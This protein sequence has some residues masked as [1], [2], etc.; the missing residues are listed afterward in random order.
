MKEFSW[1]NDREWNIGELVLETLLFSS[2]VSITDLRLCAN[3]SWFT[4]PVTKEERTGNVQLLSEFISKQTG[5]QY[6]DLNT[7]DFSSNANLAVLT[8]I[9][10]F[11]NSSRL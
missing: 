2:I 6:L 1:F 3:G 8:K 11:G 10:N 7:D 4:N 5:L 9:A